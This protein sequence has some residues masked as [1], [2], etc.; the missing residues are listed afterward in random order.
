VAQVDRRIDPK[1]RQIHFSVAYGWLRMAILPIIDQERKNF[2][3]E[4][5]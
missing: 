4:R 3:N 1:W 5:V 2:S